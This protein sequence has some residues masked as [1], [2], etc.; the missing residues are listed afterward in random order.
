MA[1]TTSPIA[2]GVTTGGAPMV[3]WNGF[4]EG[5]AGVVD[6]E[7]HR[8]EAAPADQRRL[9]R[10]IDRHQAAGAEAVGTRGERC[11]VARR[12]GPG[13]TEHL[14]ATV[15]GG[16]VD[17]YGEGHLRASSEAAVE[18]NTIAAAPWSNSDD[19]PLVRDGRPDQSQA[20]AT[21]RARHSSCMRPG[22]SAP[23]RRM[24]C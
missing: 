19:V 1:Y 24:N 21:A 8:G 15:I 7:H 11:G 18:R 10:R 23:I 14:D 13:L 12:P 4:A 22:S 16:V 3:P 9:G 2:G 17:R 5:Q 6:V 20:T